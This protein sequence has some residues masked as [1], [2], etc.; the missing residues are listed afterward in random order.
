MIMAEKCPSV[1]T[2]PTPTG[3]CLFLI[4]VVIISNSTS[5]LPWVSVYF[6]L[7]SLFPLSVPLHFNNL[8]CYNHRHFSAST[9]IFYILFCF[10][11]LF[12]WLTKVALLKA[13]LQGR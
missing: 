3:S 5:L 1:Q 7:L 9:N 8:I 6:H 10:V 11:F 4:F 12:V 2:K 13:D